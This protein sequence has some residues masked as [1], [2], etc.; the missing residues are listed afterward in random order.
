MGYTTEFDGSF[1][2]EFTDETKR[3]KVTNLVNGLASTRRIGRDLS[4]TDK[5]LEHPIEY[6]G[7]EGEFYYGDD[8]SSFG[9]DNDG[10]ILNYNKAPST[11]PGLW[12]QWIIEDN[13]LFWDSGEK[14]YNYV[15]WL[16]YLVE[17]IFKPNGVIVSGTVEWRGEE[18]SDNG[19]I[20]V[21][22]NVITTK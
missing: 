2:L 6:Y 3:E 5:S 9:Q 7:V 14:F 1:N 4:K 19:E 13:S 12:L 20:I 16:D 8:T 11:Q 21:T 15:P 18:W 10:S 17:K 22:D